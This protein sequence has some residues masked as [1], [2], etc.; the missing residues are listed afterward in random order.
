M[1]SEMKASGRD[2]G[3][4]L[5][6]TA[7]IFGV[8][9]LHVSTGAL[10]AAI[11]SPPWLGALFW[12]CAVR[13]SVP[14]F[15][16][17]SGAL[18]LPP[19]KD[20]PL[21]RLYG[22]NFLR[23]VLAMLVWA[24]FY[25]V[26]HLAAS[27]TLSVGALWQAAKEVLVFNQEF[28]LYYLHIL[29]LVYAVLPL[30][31][32]FVRH[33]TEK[34]LRYALILWFAL[35]ICFPTVRTFWPVT[36]LTDIPLQ[37]MLNMSWAAVGYGL[38]GYC[39]A[40]RLPSV[41]LGAILTAAGFMLVFGPTLGL[42]LKSGALEQRFLEGMSVGVCLM[43]A[44][45]FTLLCRLGSALRGRRSGDFVTVI[46][47]S[48]FCIYLVH[49]AWLRVF[50]HLG[51]TAAAFAPIVS[52]P[53]LALCIAAVSWGCWWLLSKVPVVNRWLV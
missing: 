37:W 52:V 21:K 26:L 43:A 18:M 42:S 53:L 17:C 30:T 11:G 34:E 22:K 20:L 32:A 46:S 50:Q 38:L 36:L 25:K 19:K 44:G 7:A 14:L 47:R 39:L 41:W 4:D 2:V 51:L 13:A 45:L 10:D 40:R 48:S 3:I 28:H 1:G 29:L 24:M 31:R 15:F 35:G 16:L 6:K 9:A 27:G 49:V 5:V 8:A 33:S 12:T 23:L